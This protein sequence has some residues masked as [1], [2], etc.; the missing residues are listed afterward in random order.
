[1]GPRR[2]DAT[3]RKAAGAYY[4]PERVVKSLVR[5]AVR[6]P[7]HRLLDPSCGDGRFLREHQPSVGIEQ[8]P[9]SAAVAHRAAPGSLVH[10]GDFFAW[11][12]E[13]RERF[14]CAAGNPPFIRYQRF[15]GEVRERAR[16]LCRNQGVSVSALSS[17]WAPFLIATVGLL[18]DGGRMA[19]VVPAELGH[20]PYAKPVLDHMMRSFGYVHVLAVRNRLISSVSAGC[21]L[22]YASGRGRHTH[23]LNLSVVDSFAYSPRP[24]TRRDANVI[25]R[26]E[27]NNWNGRLRPFLLDLEVRDSYRHA[28]S[29]AVCLGDLAKVGV[30]YVTGANEFFH[31]RP[32][33]ARRLRLP[34]RHLVPSVRSGRVLSGKRLT[35]ASVLRWHRADEPYLLLRLSSNER[36]GKRVTAYLQSDHAAEARESF[37]CKVRD[38]W[39]SVPNVRVPCGFLSYM[40]GMG[41]SLVQNSAG[42]VGT[43][44][45]HGVHLRAGVSRL[46]LFDAWSSDLT[47][48]SC[49]IEGHP[50]GGGLLKLEPTRA[51]RVLVDTRAAAR[52][53]ADVAAR[54]LAT[55][56]LWRGVKEA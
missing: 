9:E 23:Q 55:M 21:W 12:S 29:E 49:E 8:D 5:W 47:A 28:T 2:M 44:S 39:Y 42:C 16:R 31:L 38:P 43:N 22:L 3:R 46:A 40:S 25:S 37:K 6:Q 36:L 26:R 53:S 45:V 41:P 17:S 34:D 24:P 56:R 52:F 1:M 11:A 13:T 19:F 48:L 30:G 51:A 20:A 54:G 4:T 15:A 50:L 33:E 27:L 14:E 10:E 32:S 35:R 7:T 18:K